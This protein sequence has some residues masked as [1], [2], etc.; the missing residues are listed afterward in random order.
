MQWLQDPSQSSVD[1]LNNVRCEAS[2]HYRNKDDYLK[3]KIDELETNGKFKN[4]RD[5]CR[6]ISDFKE[7]YQ[8]GTNIGK[9]EKG[10]LVTDS[11][12][13]LARWS[14]HFSQLFNVHGV[15]DVRQTEIHTAEPL[16]A[17]EFEM[18]IGKLKRQKSPGTDQFPAELI[19]AVGRTICSET[20]KF[21]NY[22][23]NKE[24]LPEEWKELI[25]V[26]IYRKGNKR[27]CVN[28][29]GISL[30]TGFFF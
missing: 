23:W 5:L 21:I 19:T 4:I 25:S 16:S 12:S 11:N 18:A 9:D 13:V 24:E 29:R 1:N 7:G 15:S 27:D 22:I 3:A 17:C 2:R 30:L 28:Y 8:P 10:D 20:H 14:N 6:S 26:P